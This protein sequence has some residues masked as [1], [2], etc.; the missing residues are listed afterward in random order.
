MYRKE[1]ICECESY[2]LD[3]LSNTTVQRSKNK[4]DGEFE[5]FP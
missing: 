3:N 1:W 4:R 2:I 5:T